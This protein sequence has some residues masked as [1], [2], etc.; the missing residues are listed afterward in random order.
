MISTNIINL[1][2]HMHFT[3][4]N[5]LFT[6]YDSDESLIVKACGRSPPDLVTSTGSSITVVFK[7]DSSRNSTGFKAVW[8]TESMKSIKSPNYP[9]YY[10]DNVHESSRNSNY[11]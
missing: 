6:V 11:M 2:S 8:T 10:P 3:I 1:Y 9:L 4:L 7:T 5:A